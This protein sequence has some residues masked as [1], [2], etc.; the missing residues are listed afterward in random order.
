MFYLDS[1]LWIVPLRSVCMGL[2]EH[3]SALELPPIFISKVHTLHW[4]FLLECWVSCD[5][6]LLPT[7]RYLLF[8]HNSQ[9]GVLCSRGS[10]VQWNDSFLDNGLTVAHVLKKSITWLPSMLQETSSLHLDTSDNKNPSWIIYCI[11]KNTACKASCFVTL[12]N[13]QNMMK[14]FYLYQE[15]LCYERNLIHLE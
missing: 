11:R 4:I 2:F 8:H 15:R 12:I 5:F 14:M 6:I 3:I 10:H 7:Q 1:S 13:Q 9:A